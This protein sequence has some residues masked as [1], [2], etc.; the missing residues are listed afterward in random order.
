VVYFVTGKVATSMGGVKMSIPK[1]SPYS[2]IAQGI[3]DGWNTPEDA[4]RTDAQEYSRYVVSLVIKTN[5][6]QLVWA[7]GDS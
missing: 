2:P 4:Q 1:D 5:P 3:I 7:G 6:P